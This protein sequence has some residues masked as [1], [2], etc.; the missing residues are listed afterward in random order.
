MTTAFWAGLFCLV[1][2]M[3]NLVSI[4]LAGARIHRRVRLP[5]PLP[6]VEAVTIIRPVRGIEPFIEETLAAGFALDFPAYELIFCV[7]QPDD[8]VMDVIIRL[9]A[10]H[11]QV[12]ARLLVGEDR[13]SGNPK[14]NN[15]VKGWQAARHDWVILADS[16]VL[17]PP[18]YIQQLMSSWRPDTGLVC[19]TPLG[20]RPDGFWADVECAFLNTLQARWQYA[21]ECV[22]LGFAQGKSML[23]QRAFLNAQGG[24][25]ALAA[26]IAEDAAATKLVRKAGQHVHL[27]DAPFEQPL[28][29]RTAREVWDRQLR[30]ARL[31]R[32]TFPA[33]FAPEILS[34]GTVPLVAGLGAAALADAS[35]PLVAA[36]L[37]VLW[38]GAEAA[39]AA[40]KGWY[41]SWRLIA[42]CILRDAVIPAL[43]ICAW[44]AGN[45]V[46]RGNAMK[47][48]SGKVAPGGDASLVPG[49]GDLAGGGPPRRAPDD[50][51]RPATLEPS[52]Y[53]VRKAPAGKGVAGERSP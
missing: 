26:E 48:C 41:L 42:A 35:L 16:N 1:L 30:W 17:M 37:L 32:V 27:V 12:A 46:W 33:F 9:M 2:T 23:W 49:G 53:R 38:Y 4:G 29:R 15:C 25:Q 10:A 24:I 44:A 19:S 11:P 6:P 40:S 31:R 18:D 20:A 51:A 34:G 39:L 50:V 43:W 52:Q 13:I 22:G 7:E 47:I 36:A 14:L 3:V 28:G 5:P 8:P 21:G 45:T